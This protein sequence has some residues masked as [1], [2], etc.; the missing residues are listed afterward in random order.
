MVLFLPLL[1]L[2]G[3]N[4]KILYWY[5]EEMFY[6]WILFILD[7]TISSLNY[8]IVETGDSLKPIIQ[9]GQNILFM[10]NHQSVADVLI[11]IS[12]LLD[13]PGC[14]KKIMWIIGK[15]QRFTNFGLMSWLHDDF[16][17]DTGKGN[18][19][20]A[21]K[22]LKLHISN[23]FQK[24]NRKCIIL[25]PEGGFLSKK[26][27]SSDLYAKKNKLPILCNVSYPRVGALHAILETW[28]NGVAEKEK[29]TFGP[30]IALKTQVCTTN[31]LLNVI[32][33]VVKTY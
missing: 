13:H 28:E 33:S 23:S 2:G 30:S 21:L 1:V 8:K 4:G 3:E 12:I 24:R 11:C 19:Q 16:F 20:R 32:V 22:E 6:E 10:P 31:C 7:F 26:K 17:L 14:V 29:K 9:R 25:F 18:Q 15:N 5:I 27:Y